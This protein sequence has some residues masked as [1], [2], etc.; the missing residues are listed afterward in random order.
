[1]SFLQFKNIRI[2]DLA[3]EFLIKDLGW[4]KF[5]IVAIMFISHIQVVSPLIEV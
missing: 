1:M 5:E 3:A 4:E 2:A